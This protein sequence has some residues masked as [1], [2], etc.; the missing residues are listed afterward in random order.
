[1]YILNL[2]HNIYYNMQK[3]YKPLGECTV[4][5]LLLT[6]VRCKTRSASVRRQE[7]DGFDI[8]PEPRYN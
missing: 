5:A 8:R 2:L 7:G 4:Y 3:R 6:R 1:M